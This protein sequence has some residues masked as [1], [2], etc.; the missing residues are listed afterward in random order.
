MKIQYNKNSGYRKNRTFSIL[1]SVLILLCVCGWGQSTPGQEKSEDYPNLKDLAED[2]NS[3][4]PDQLISV[5][6]E[7]V[8]IRV[9]LKTISDISGINFIIDDRVQG[10]VTVI[11]P[12]KIKLSEVYKM[13]ES[14]LDVKGYTAV[15]VGDMVKIVPETEAAHGDLNVRIGNSPSLI[16]DTDTV[17]TQ[18]IPLEYIQ[19]E[20]IEK[21]IRPLL[22]KNSHL[23]LYPRTNSILITGASSNIKHISEIIDELDVKGSERVVKVFNMEYASPEVMSKKLKELMKKDNVSS[24]RRQAGAAG[25]DII[26]IPD[27]RTNSLVV[28]AKP[29]E[30]RKIREFISKVDIKR[31]S[32]ANNVHVVYLDNAQAEEVAES[33]N[34]ALSHLRISGALEEGKNVQISPDKGTNGLIITASAQDFEVISDIIEKLDI[35]REQ[36]LVEMLIVEVS[37]DSLQ[38]IGIDWATMDEAVSDSVRGFGSTNFGPR[39]DYAN[40]D[41]GGLNIGAMKKVDGETSIGAILHILDKKSGLNILSTPQILTSNHKQAKIVVGQNRPFVVKSRVTETDVDTPTVIKTY[42][43]KDVGITLEITPHVSQSDQVRLEIDTKFTKLLKSAT[44]D[45]DTPTTAK[46][47][48]MTIV[49]TK[50]DSTIVIGGLIRDDEV[51]MN[52]KIP[53]LG[54]LPLFGG[55]FRYTSIEQEKTN[56]LFFITPRV[57]RDPE[58][59]ESV[60]NEKKTEIK[61]KLKKERQDLMNEQF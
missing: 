39:V 46:R 6:F 44:V 51:T 21:I 4:D 49:S 24:Q 9:M 47:Q 2:V 48:A 34:D 52:K 41:L 28:K 16:P 59:I 38:E 56:L 23:S 22:T 25:T 32:R 43:Y 55:L 17:I 30:I 14:I 29:D 26:V 53:I 35:V 27:S 54:D 15:P 37:E 61:N 20:D 45:S 3:E 10:K 19:T 36:I 12:T 8:D 58:K 42:E 31:P 40:G 50:S 57:L 13:L 11:S 18:I 1:F 7:E 5:N 60:T 33:L